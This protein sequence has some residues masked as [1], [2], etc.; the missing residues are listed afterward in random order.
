MCWHRSAL[1]TDPREGS[2][3]GI[4]FEL[5]Q[6]EILA[7]SCGNLP[8]PTV[9]LRKNPRRSQPS[10][11]EVLQLEWDANCK[12][13]DAPELQAQDFPYCC[14]FNRWMRPANGVRYAQGGHRSSLCN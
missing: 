2:N 9:P 1:P 11:H 5:T 4:P 6:R 10:R 12:Q 7:S 13:L 3:L 8:Q 14:C